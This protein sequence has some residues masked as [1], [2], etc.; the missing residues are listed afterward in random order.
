MV[1]QPAPLEV[2][3]PIAA[4]LEAQH[5][6]HGIKAAL[7]AVKRILVTQGFAHDGEIHR[8]ARGH[9]GKDLFDRVKGRFARQQIGDHPLGDDHQ[10]MGGG[11][12]AVHHQ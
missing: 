3:G 11:L 4:S 6:A 5:T 12:S 8:V 9:G 7:E 10:L 2:M 1:D